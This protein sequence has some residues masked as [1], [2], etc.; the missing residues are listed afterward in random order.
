MLTAADESTASSLV[1]LIVTCTVVVVPSAA[2][3][4]NWSD[5]ES[6][7]FS[8]STSLLAVYVHTPALVTENVPFVPATFVCATNVSALSTSA[9]VSV[10]PVVSGASVSSRLTAADESTASSLVPL[11][12]SSTVV[13]VPS[14]AVTVIWSD[15]ESPTFSPPNALFAVY[16]HTPAL[17]TE[18][19]PFVPATF[20]CA[21]NVSTLSTSA[22]VSVPP[23]VSGASVSSRLAAADESTASSLVP[24][25]VTCTVVVVPSAAVTVGR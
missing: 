7:S 21:T 10:P 1:P 2:V 20:V 11:I 13:L 6:P 5:T 4:V 14:A 24:L 19:V 16:V 22:F 18:N 23:V 15:T 25:I 8:S 9:F 3:T 17:V 12:V